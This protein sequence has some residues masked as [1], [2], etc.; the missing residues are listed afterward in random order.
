L[1]LTLLDR[2]GIPMEQ[3]ADSNGRFDDLFGPVS[4]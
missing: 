4:L 1:H 2:V 3:F